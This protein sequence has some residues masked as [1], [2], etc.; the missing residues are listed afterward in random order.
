[1]T[2]IIPHGTDLTALIPLCSAQNKSSELVPLLYSGS[3]FYT[4]PYR[5]NLYCA[6]SLGS[7]GCCLIVVL[8]QSCLPLPVFEPDYTHSSQAKSVE[9]QITGKFF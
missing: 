9:F 1:M 3:S 5:I 6:V 7:H 8:G 2:T 4:L